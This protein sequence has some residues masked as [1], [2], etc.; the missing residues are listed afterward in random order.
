MKVSR[1]IRGSELWNTG[2]EICCRVARVDK[3]IQLE[4][5]P[6]KA[7]DEIHGLAE[8]LDLIDILIGKNVMK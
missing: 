1:S 2:G 5:M 7:K 4:T 8:T 6:D 3:L